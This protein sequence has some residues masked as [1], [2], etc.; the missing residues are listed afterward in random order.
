LK[1]FATFRVTGD[2][3]VPDEV[4]Q[5]LKVQPT[6]VR[7]KGKPYSTG[8]S[9]NIIPSTNIWFFSTDTVVFSKNI[10]DHIRL[11]LFILGLMGSGGAE[12]L[13]ATLNGRSTQ[14]AGLV[15][16]KSLL[17]RSPAK[18]A[19]TIFWHGSSGSTV[20]RIP[21]GLFDVLRLIDV[22]VDV[23]FDKDEDD[24]GRIGRGRRKSA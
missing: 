5:L 8:K 17:E 9:G 21:D 12:I 20:P 11:V 10:F 3:L 24:L 2:N 1:T 14:F 16:L 4:T 22:T 15:A 18:A 6:H 19:M 7:L 13:D 23:D